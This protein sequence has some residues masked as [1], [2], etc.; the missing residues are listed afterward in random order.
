MTLRR[1]K[2]G[3]EYTCRKETPC[4]EQAD[5]ERESK[6]KR[7]KKYSKKFYKLVQGKKKIGL[8]F[9]REWGIRRT[10]ILLH[11]M[12]SQLPQYHYPSYQNPTQPAQDYMHWKQSM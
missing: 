7:F 1:R 2:K 6:K 4:L 5:R 3:K 11:N 12:H 8:S 9:K 10:S